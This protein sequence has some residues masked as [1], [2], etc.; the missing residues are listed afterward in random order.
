LP[1]AVPTV[2]PSATPSAG[3]TPGIPAVSHSPEETA[4]FNAE[5]A[6]RAAAN[7]KAAYEAAWHLARKA[8]EAAAADT[9]NKHAE[10]ER[11]NSALKES[12]KEAR[13]ATDDLRDSSSVTASAVG[14]C[15]LNQVDP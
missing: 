7:R 9:A 14:L 1:S 4:L 8:A 5:E 13:Q 3:P 10:Y 11:L 6:L 15:R 12:E 2:A